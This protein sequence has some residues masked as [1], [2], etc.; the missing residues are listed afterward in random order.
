ML[1]VPR[2]LLV[3]LLL[4]GQFAAIAHAFEHDPGATQSQA[5]ASCVTVAQLGSALVDHPVELALPDP[6]FEYVS[7][8]TAAWSSATCLVVRQRGPPSFLPTL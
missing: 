6:A 2:L 7:A 1:S 8:A 3:L 4:G 5:C